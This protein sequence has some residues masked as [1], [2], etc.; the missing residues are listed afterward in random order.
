MKDYLEKKDPKNP[1]LK[2]IGAV[3]PGEK[4]DLPYWMGSLDKI[5]EDEKVLNNWKT[6]YPGDVIISDK[7]DGNSALLVINKKGAKMYSRGDGFKGQ[8]ISHLIS[9][10][11]G[12][13]TSTKE[14]YAIRGELI[15]SKENWSS[16]GKGAN[17][18]NAVAGLMHSKVPDPELVKYVD[19][20]L[21]LL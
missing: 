21:R 2:E 17:A 20:H 8:D 12:I 3:A 7:L 19:F 11:K 4:V 14:E 16:H 1:I 10:I 15:I 6:K 9:L 18:R 13:P 5:R